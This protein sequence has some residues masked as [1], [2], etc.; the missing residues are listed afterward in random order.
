VVR[1]FIAAVGFAAGGALV[2]VLVDQAERVEPAGDDTGAVDAEV[3]RVGLLIERHD[4]WTGE[5]P[6]PD[7][8]PGHAIVTLPRQ[9]AQRVSSDVGFGIWLGP[10][11]KSGTGD[12]RAGDLW[13]FCP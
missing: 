8:I 7:I 13:A 11:G 12:E 3:A 4:C 1:G 10:D 5:A 6:D 9:I 2:L